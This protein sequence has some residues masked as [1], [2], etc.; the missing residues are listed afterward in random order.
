VEFPEFSELYD[1]IFEK[2]LQEEIKPDITSFRGKLVLKLRKYGVKVEAHRAG[3]TVA[4]VTYKDEEER[5]LAIDFLKKNGIGKGWEYVGEVPQPI[6]YYKRLVEGEDFAPT[7]PIEDPLP[8]FEK[9]MVRCGVDK[10]LAS[11]IAKR[12]KLD[13]AQA[14]PI[15]RE[16]IRFRIAQLAL[17]GC[18][19]YDLPLTQI[20][21][22][23]K[24]LTPEILE[25]L[26]LGWNF[27][28]SYYLNNAYD[29][30]TLFLR[31]PLTQEE[32]RVLKE[33]SEYMSNMGFY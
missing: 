33:L 31:K 29:Y 30:R 6:E 2:G 5:D 18:L 13:F 21:S 24:A 22:T 3:V 19:K 11:F 15:T 12:L 27:N 20:E 28:V 25:D 1:M 16:L 9:S 23:L 17:V 26:W 32:E 10:R 14:T 7:W 4:L 8:I